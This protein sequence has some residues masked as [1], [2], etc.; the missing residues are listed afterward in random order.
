MEKEGVEKKKYNKL[1]VWGFVLAIIAPI[2]LIF[3]YI[4]FYNLYYIS[5]P[6]E[7][8]MA[9]H[10]FMSVLIFPG[11]VLVL[12]LISIVFSVISLKKIKKTG[13]SGK[14]FAVASLIISGIIA[15]I[16]VFATSS[17]LSSELKSRPTVSTEKGPGDAPW[18]PKHLKTYTPYHGPPSTTGTNGKIININGTDFC[19]EIITD[20]DWVTDTIDTKFGLFNEDKS[21][22][23]TLTFPEPSPSKYGKC[24]ITINNQTSECNFTY[25]WG[26][27]S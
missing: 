6:L 7:S 18:C 27:I 17:H 8:Y 14:N 24:S 12:C 10:S 15:V 4:L 11:I 1:A 13:E 26:F 9:N 16:L 25:Y 21:I 22:N 23:I 19:F 2:L 5:Q 3:L 20:G